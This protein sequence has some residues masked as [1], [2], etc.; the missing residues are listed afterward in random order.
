MPSSTLPW[1]QK[2]MQTLLFFI[3]FLS[4]ISYPNCFLELE[5]QNIPA[6]AVEAKFLLV[7]YGLLNLWAS[8]YTYKY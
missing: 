4:I 3:S 7:S 8:E 2:E 5:S 6:V 1:G